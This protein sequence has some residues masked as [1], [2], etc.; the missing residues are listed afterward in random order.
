MIRK[1][2]I[3][4]NNAISEA[5][6]ICQPKGDACQPT[7]LSVTVCDPDEDLGCRVRDGIHD[8]FS[9]LDLYGDY[10]DKINKEK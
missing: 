8:Y 7:Q 5:I 1:P 10:V 4:S 9:G 2:P 3:P 6:V